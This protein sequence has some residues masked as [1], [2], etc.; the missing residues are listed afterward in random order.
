LRE[1]FIFFSKSVAASTELIEMK[2]AKMM[3]AISDPTEAFPFEFA[4]ALAPP[5]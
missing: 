3:A 5:I 2:H 1:V 4:L